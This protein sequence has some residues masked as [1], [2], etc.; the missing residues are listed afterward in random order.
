V[1]TWTSSASSQ[2]TTSGTNIYYNSGNVGIGTNNP[3]YLLHVTGAAASTVSN[4][5]VEAGTNATGQRSEIRFGIPAFSGTGKRAGITSNTYTSDGSNLQFWTNASGGTLSTPQMTILPS[6]F[7]G[8]GTTSPAYKLETSGGAIAVTGTNNY[9]YY[10]V[11]NSS[12]SGAYMMF[13]A[14]TAGGSGRK[15]QIGTTGTSNNPGT[16]CFE[17][18]DA[19]VN[20][21]R[22]VVNA[23]GNVGI[24]M[25]N[26]GYLVDV[27]G[28]VNSTGSFRIN[29]ILQPK[30]YHYNSFN[31]VTSFDAG[32]FDLVN[33]NNV[34]IRVIPAFNTTNSG[35]LQIQALDTAGTVYGAAEAGYVVWQGNRS[36]AFAYGGS[37]TV[38]GNTELITNGVGPYI[39]IVRI[40]SINAYTGSQRFHV[41]WTSTGCWAG[42][43]AATDTGQCF[44]ATTNIQLNR[45][46]FNLT[47]GTMTGKYSIVHYL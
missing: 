31:G 20:A 46:R 6:G 24:G 7:V 32:N 23:S 26:P 42:T 8:I 2:W 29:T 43:G 12:S 38:F 40:T 37:A 28:D 10:A 47:A 13:D 16:G 21:T 14:Q 19:T 45:I 18:Y 44:F 5:V 9:L 11:T 36:T 22:M 1:P 15:Y 39:C 25:T 17:L 30:V 27:A 33:F 3:Q 35:A 41:Q 4:I 34:E